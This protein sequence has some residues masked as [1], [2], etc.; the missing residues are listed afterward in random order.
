MFDIPKGK[1]LVLF[2]GVCN[3]CDASVQRILK[4]DKN[5]LYVFAALDSKTG[6]AVQAHLNLASEA[7]DS[8]ILYEPGGSCDIKSTAVL[9]IGTSFGGF[10]YLLAIGWLVPRSLRDVLYDWV[11]KN[12]YRWFGK[13]AACRIPTPVEQA[14][15]LP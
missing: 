5:N 12:R 9:K 4:Y 15:F 11:A 6:S 14:K 3:F 10:W 8:I 13:R 1:R 7:V 2:D